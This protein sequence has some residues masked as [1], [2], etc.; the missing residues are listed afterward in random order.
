MKILI[1]GATGFIGSN[2]V[3]VLK[4]KYNVRVLVRR[5]VGIKGVEIAY[6]DLNDR[7]AVVKALKEVDVAYYLVHSMSQTSK[8]IKMETEHAKNFVHA[9]D[10]NNVKRIIYL[11]GIIPKGRLSRHLKSRKRVG[12][13]L[14]RSRAKVT[15]FRASIVVGRKGSSFVIIQKLVEN[16][17]VLIW[18]KQVKDS[19][20]QPIALEDVLYYLTRSLEEKKT[21]GKTYDIGGR[22]VITFKD[23]LMIY[24]EEIGR[25]R[26]II[27]IP[28]FFPR[29]YA[30]LASIITKQPR[31]LIQALIESLR[32][33]V[34]CKENKIRKILPRKVLSY[35]EA[36]K[37]S[38]KRET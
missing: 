32:Y 8:F 4:K 20:N 10:A 19:L 27:Y 36:V 34:V 13:M 12:D 16:M 5:K 33:D 3:N 29:L 25:K 1:T 31:S 2:L 18:P 30:Y 17:P 15:E 26:R 6:G 23:M 9:C 22:D 28:F 38:I 11:S 37:A 35:R 21:I 24:S 14:R 7:K